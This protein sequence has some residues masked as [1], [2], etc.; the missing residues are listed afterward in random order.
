MLTPKRA[1]PR[2]QQGFYALVC[3][4]SVVLIGLELTNLRPA[5]AP[6][7]PDPSSDRAELSRLL[8]ETRAV[9]TRNEALAHDG[10]PI[11]PYQLIGHG[12]DLGLIFDTANQ[13]T[14]DGTAEVSAFRQECAQGTATHLT[15]E[16]L[17]TGAGMALARRL[18]MS[19]RDGAARH[20]ATF[21]ALQASIPRAIEMLKVDPR[22]K[23]IF[24]QDLGTRI[25]RIHEL[26]R[27]IWD[28][29]VKL[30]DV[31]L[32]QL[33]M[34][35]HPRGAWR[36]VNGRFDFT[37]HADLAEFKRGEALTADLVAQRR[38]ATEAIWAANN[39]VVR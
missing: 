9:Q 34:L 25:P 6:R 14:R 8:S 5:V 3:V 1:W 29:D 39:Y 36:A 37:N 35:A 16:M 31:E 20:A 15:P 13:I 22:V 38:E 11:P 23:S 18:V 17:A 2:M 7:N 26:S 28:I 4:V 30:L 12:D 10:Q 27:Q 33:D 19:C 24:Y 32:R 21:L